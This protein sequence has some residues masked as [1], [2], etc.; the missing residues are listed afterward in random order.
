MPP[1]T[2]FLFMGFTPVSSHFLTTHTF[3]SF[4]PKSETNYQGLMFPNWLDKG[5]IILPCGKIYVYSVGSAQDGKVGCCFLFLP[6]LQRILNPLLPHP[7]WLSTPHK[8]CVLAGAEQGAGRGRVSPLLRSSVPSCCQCFSLSLEWL[9]GEGGTHS[10]AWNPE[11]TC[12]AVPA[13][14]S[15]P[16]KLARKPRFSDTLKSRKDS[17]VQER[18]ALPCYPVGSSRPWI[19][20][21]VHAHSRLR[22]SLDIGKWAYFGGAI[23]L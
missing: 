3:P 9:L 4:H 17:S 11:H 2:T 22:I 23:Y 7:P 13:M 6:H 12:T 14:C 10:L 5:I 1:I 18:S 8:T 20:L 21:C 16:S 15:V 19:C